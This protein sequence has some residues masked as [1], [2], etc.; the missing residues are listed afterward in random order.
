MK[1]MN[2]LKAS[3]LVLPLLASCSVDMKKIE[4][5]AAM[6]NHYEEVSLKLARDNRELHAEVKRLEFEVEKLKHGSSFHE[7]KSPDAVAHGE[8]STHETKHEESKH[9]E[10]ATHESKHEENKREE[11]THDAHGGRA[12]ASVAPS[13][14]SADAKKDYVEFKTYKWHADDLMQIADKEFKEK[15]YEKAAQFYKS[16]VNNY[17]TNKSITDEFYFKAGIAAYESGSHHDW[18]LSHFET[19]MTKY[20]TS[21]YFRSAK[22]WVALTHMKLGDKKKFYAT[23]EE[24]RKKYRN[25]NEWKILSSYY[26]K[27]EEKTNE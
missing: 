11:V 14:I 1:K 24:F 3:L 12:I 23:V 22:L 7:S 16:L 26:E 4:E 17:P 21:Q 18:T 8:A 25:T 19:L 6:I 2:K 5:K 10:I 20:P 13:P 9:V 15:N 27:I